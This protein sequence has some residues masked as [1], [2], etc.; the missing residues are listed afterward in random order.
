M[1]KLAKLLT[2]AALAAVTAGAAQAE[3]L[4]LGREAL[5][6][7]I[8]AWDVAVLP[9]GTGLPEGEGDVWTGEKVFIENC[10]SCHGD[11]AEGLDNWPPLAGGEGTLTQRRPVK[12]V[13]SYWPYLSTVWDYVHRSMPFGAAQTMSADDTY[14]MTAYILY[15]NNLVDDDF[16]LSKETFGDV[17]MPNADGFVVDDR[18]ETEY[19]VFSGEACMSDCRE[20]VEITARA[21]D[22]NVTPKGEDGKP[23]GTLPPIMAS[24]EAEEAPVEE[25]AA[26]E[27][28]PV[29]EVA[30]YDPELVAEGEK[31]FRKCQ[32]CHKVG[33]GARNGTGPLLN[34]VMGHQA[35]M[36]EGFRYSKALLE[37][38]ENGLVWTEETL[39]AY[40]AD[41][42]GYI[43]RN[44]MS[45][46]GLRKQEEIDAVI[47]YIATAGAE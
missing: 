42:R 14:A 21:V 11:F 10:A 33:E 35:G 26:E 9:D 41:P 15:S 32:A 25:A 45:F 18:A 28:A 39:G 29:E 24:A 5:P 7:E 34:G 20:P 47:A 46:A 37:A 22:L 43:P 3:G 17:V 12:T 40:L 16:V 31:V 2:G 4:G 30:A 6:E 1:S 13:G 36:V 23:E 38:G 8:A 19:P 27:A 44:K